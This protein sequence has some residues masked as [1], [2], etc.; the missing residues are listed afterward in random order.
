MRKVRASSAVAVYRQLMK[1]GLNAQN[2]SMSDIEI[3]RQSP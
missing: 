1:P 3:F 2:P